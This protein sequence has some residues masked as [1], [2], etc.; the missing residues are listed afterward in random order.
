MLTGTT[1]IWRSASKARPPQC[2]PPMLEGR[3]SVPRS[4][5]GVKMPSF[6]SALITLCAGHTIGC[7]EVPEVLQ[8][9]ALRAQLDGAERLRLRCAFTRDVAGWHVAL[10][11]REQRLAGVSM[12]HEQ[13]AGLGRLQD[14]GHVLAAAPD[15]GE[16][17]GRRIVVVPEIVMDGLEMPGDVAGR[18]LKRDDRVRVAV[19][20]RPQASEVVRARARSRREDEAALR[21]GHHDRPDVCRTGAR[22]T[23]ILPA[24]MGGIPC[25]LR[26]RI[27]AS[28]G[29]C[30]CGRRRRALRRSPA[31]CGCCRR[32]R[33]R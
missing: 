16:G 6:R 22:G 30:R 9:E 33:N 12:Q 25:V 23:S 15:R 21:V 1:A 5:G 4:E 28:T 8:R 14:R 2:A 13:H 17:G 7:V 32:S 29:A 26:D 24:G 27:P 3:A 18:G 31:R 19:V 10:F 11:D 20:A